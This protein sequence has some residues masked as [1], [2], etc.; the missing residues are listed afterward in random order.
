MVRHGGHDVHQ[1][2]ATARSVLLTVIL[3]GSML[4]RREDGS[5]LRGV[6][7]RWRVATRSC[8]AG[9]WAGSARRTT[10]PW[11][12]VIRARPGGRAARASATFACG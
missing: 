11:L 6:P 10:P 12:A 9:S 1:L 7:F 8:A 2:G 5:L 4:D 3:L